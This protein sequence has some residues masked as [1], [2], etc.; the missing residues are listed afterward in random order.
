MGRL[1]ALFTGN[2]VTMVYVAAA[3]AGVSYVAGGY[4]GWTL[5]GWRLGAELEQAEHERDHWRDQSAV[6]ADA[7]RSCSAGVDQAKRAGDAAVAAGDELRAAAKRLN[8]P[9]EQTV[10]RLERLV[11]G[12]MT[13]EQAADCGWAW[14]QLETEYQNRMAG[15]P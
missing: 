6:V 15:R 8:L 4:S 12:A 2:P 9:L 1:L 14:Q 13:P 7:A 3:I 10:S 11:S 5:N